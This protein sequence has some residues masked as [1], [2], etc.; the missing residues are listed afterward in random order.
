MNGWGITFQS[1]TVFIDKAKL[2]NII[3]KVESTQAEKPFMAS[4]LLFVDDELAF[5]QAI[6]Q[7]FRKEIKSGEYEIIFTHSGEE[8]LNAIDLAQNHQIDLL[9]TDLK[10]PAAQIDGFQLLRTLH[11]KDIYLKTIVISAYGDMENYQQALRENVLL[12]LPKPIEIM[13]LKPLIEEALNRQ[14]TI[15]ITPQKVGFKPIYQI[16]KKLPSR[17]KIKLIE[18]LIEHLDLEDL[19]A[20]QE[21]L[22]DKLTHQLAIVR[23]TKEEKDALMAKLKEGKIDENDLELLEG[24]IIEKK[25]IPKDGKKFGPYYYLRWWEDGRLKNKYLGKTDPRQK[26]LREK[27]P[28]SVS[29]KDS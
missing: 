12:F 19:E 11:E 27:E 29:Q 22:P 7:R 21:Q 5:E 13:N 28:P 6:K 14:E 23:K 9:L 16:F 1:N 2:T 24:Y 18:R 15:D 25:Y 26:H 10:M 17:R 4:K 20:L 8:A 3:I